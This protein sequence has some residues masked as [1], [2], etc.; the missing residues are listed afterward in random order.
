MARL[1]LA[2]C[3]SLAYGAQ[4]ASHLSHRLGERLGRPSLEEVRA[5][6][7]AAGHVVT[8]DLSR[9]PQGENQAWRLALPDRW[10]S[11]PAERRRPPRSL[12][13]FVDGAPLA[14][15][16]TP[17]PAGHAGGRFAFYDRP[18]ATNVFVRCL[19]A[20]GCAE[21]VVV[22]DAAGLSFALKTR[23]LW[24]ALDQVAIVLGGMAVVG[25]LAF[26][27]A[28]RWASP[29]PVLAVALGLLPAL[30]WFYLRVQAS[31]LAAPVLVVEALALA[32]PLLV[33]ALRLAG[34]GDVR[35]GL[36]RVFLAA[37]SLG[38]WAFLSAHAGGPVGWD[39][40]LYMD[41]S[42]NPHAETAFANR[43]VHIYFQKLFLWAAGDALSGAKLYWAFIV[44]TA[45]LL[46]TVCARWL[47]PAAHPL[48]G[49]LGP[50]LFLSQ[51]LIFEYAGVTYAD[52]TVM[53]LVAAGVTAYIAWLRTG[54][55]PLLAALGMLLYLA[56]RAK[57]TGLVL[58]VLLI[59]LGWQ[60]DVD[61]FR[62]RNIA[63]RAPPAL[64]GFLAA[65]AMLALGHQLFLGDALFGW[66][67]E[68][69]AAVYGFYH[70]PYEH[71]G[72]SWYGYLLSSQPLAVLFL[73]YLLS[74]RVDPPGERAP[75][76]QLLWGLPLALVLALTLSMISTIYEVHDRF[77][78]PALPVLS[79]LAAQA[80]PFARVRR[81]R[82][83]L[84]T[85]TL[86]G[87]SFALYWALD[88]LDPG[89]YQGWSRARFHRAIV[90][91]VAL[92]LLFA[93][94]VLRPA[95]RFVPRLVA[96]SALL[97]ATLHPLAGSY[98]DLRQRIVENR[99]L[100][101][102]RP[103]AVFKERIRFD[104]HTK[105]CVS[106]N[107]QKEQDALC[108]DLGS[109]MWMFN[110]YFGTAGRADQFSIADPEASW[111]AFLAPG[112]SYAFVAQKDWLAL[113]PSAR[114]ELSRRFRLEEDPAGRTPLL[115]AQ[116]GR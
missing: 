70:R 76:T 102:F 73:L 101:R 51:T 59:G 111:P 72:Q 45:A 38:L 71:E 68:D 83:H 47:S 61:G 110:V 50:L 80:V 12:L 89:G 63:K 10:L 87:L 49:A 97:V 8:V 46:V 65:A 109:C 62:W 96:L 14:F 30:P 19:P 26:H 1:W 11:G 23:R 36:W 104:A 21:A 6:T 31:R 7:P 69:V 79:V 48:N 78:L 99:S 3:L 93:V 106:Q 39:E 98:R 82:D 55:R 24:R 16:A 113:A 25:L 112:C 95:W 40:L 92:T 107:I 35:E 77:F 91:P 94:L 9:L 43:Y 42:L 2:S 85:A 18:R 20:Q 64:A 13:V 41:V 27:R 17:P 114:Q 5:A 60:K 105:V 66:R 56:P 54:R 67:G 86:L 34:S 53:L 4:L 32:L 15:Y 88:S 108:R 28:A 44:A 74:A 100:A 115:V 52:F 116:D 75:A 103:F 84:L 33:R 57:E 22:L 58:G 81:H 90:L 29:H 37:A